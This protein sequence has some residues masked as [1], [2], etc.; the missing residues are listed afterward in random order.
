MGRSTTRKPGE[1]E[2]PAAADDDLL[3][4]IAEQQR[5]TLN[6]LRQLIELLLP[7]ADPD[8]PKLEDLI[9]ALVAQQGQMLT[10]LKQLAISMNSLL[11]TSGVGTGRDGN[12]VARNGAARP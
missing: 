8:S 3:S 9:A 5:D 4:L 11:Q 2:P 12:H 7:K 1:S 6:L 10:I